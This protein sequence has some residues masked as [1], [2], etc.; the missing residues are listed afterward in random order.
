MLTLVPKVR[1]DG[2]SEREESERQREQKGK[3]EKAHGAAALH[4]GRS[5]GMGF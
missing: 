2:E 5:L 4:G 3:Q 1:D